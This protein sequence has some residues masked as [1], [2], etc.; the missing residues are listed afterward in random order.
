M[1]CVVQ[2]T[3]REAPSRKPPGRPFVDDPR[4]SLCYAPPG[5]P[6]IR[7]PLGGPGNTAP[8]GPLGSASW[9]ALGIPWGAL[10][11]HPRYPLGPPGF[12]L[13]QGIGLY[14]PERGPSGEWQLTRRLCR[15]CL[16]A[17]AVD[18]PERCLVCGCRGGARAACPCT[19]CQ[20][21]KEELGGPLFGARGLPLR[22]APDWQDRR[23]RLP[24]CHRQR[25]RPRR[26]WACARGGN[27]TAYAHH[28]RAW[29]SAR[30][31]C[32]LC[33]P[34]CLWTGFTLCMR[35]SRRTAIPTTATST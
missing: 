20:C 25:A 16:M 26:C 33:M 27:C 24:Y 35:A 8:Q 22:A 10:Q 12:S 14:V 1:L 4:C 23:A 3:P 21:T 34:L 30:A 19:T 5:C 15:A 29:A 31:A 2:A 32:L 13:L 17:L 11:A 6:Y 28:R 9:E 18:Y 7:R